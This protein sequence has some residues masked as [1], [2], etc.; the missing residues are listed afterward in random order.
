M[1]MHSSASSADT[2]FVFLI[3]FLFLLRIF[4]TFPQMFWF[5]LLFVAVITTKIMIDNTDHAGL[6]EV[7]LF[8]ALM[9]FS[10]R[11]CVIFSECICARL[12]S[13]LTCLCVSHYFPTLWSR[14]SHRH[15]STSPSLSSP[16]LFFPFLLLSFSPSVSLLSLFLTPLSV[17]LCTCIQCFSPSCSRLSSALLA[18]AH[19]ALGMSSETLGPHLTCEGQTGPRPG[20]AP[21]ARSW[22]QTNERRP[23]GWRKTCWNSGSNMLTHS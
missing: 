20:K 21:V 3:V 19:V 13:W 11:V 7:F 1:H 23:V 14:V 17:L 18:G 12:C 2:I 22:E 5:N 6:A 15:P 10:C 4:Q 9:W 16:F 8:R